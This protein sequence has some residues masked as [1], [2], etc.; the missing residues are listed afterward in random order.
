MNRRTFLSLSAVTLAAQTAARPNLLLIV[1]DD[2]GYGDLACQGAKDMRT[3]HLDALRASGMNFANCYANCPVCSP[4]RTSLMSGRYPDRVGVQGVIRLRPEDNWGYLSP[5]AVLLPEILRKAG[6]ATALVGKWHLG[7][8]PHNL[9]TARGFDQFHGMLGGMVMDYYT[10]QGHQDTKPD[11]W[12]G[13]KPARP[14]GHCT[15]IFEQWAVNTLEGWKNERRPFFLALCFNAPHTPVQPKED[16]LAKVKAREPGM[17][18]KRAKIVAL[19]EH[20]DDAVGKVLAALD[21]T[22]KRANTLVVFTSDNGGQCDQGAS[23]GPWRGCKEDM[24]EGGIRVPGFASWPG[25]IAAGSS[26]ERIQ[27]SMDISATLAEAAG[28]RYPG[29]VEGESALATWLGRTQEATARDLFW[30]R[31]EGNVRYMG[32]TIHAMR[33][34]DWKLV[35]N[36][37]FAPLELYNLR[38]DPYEKND[39]AQKNRAKFLELAA[40]LRKYIQRSAA[41]GWLAE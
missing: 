14:Q 41:V 11:M 4:T 36:S 19:I 5:K 37:P 9:P 23:N 18:E 17:S 21:Q 35:H 8:E 28:V 33:R 13:T 22:G 24:Y 1:A 7:Y 31:R 40:E 30:S 12:D 2:L 39:L 6:Y 3:P 27:L 25:R 38:D 26:T 29:P 10:H 34:G 15:D 32:K 16:W 20:M